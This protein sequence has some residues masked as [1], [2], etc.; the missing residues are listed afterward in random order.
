M[1]MILYNELLVVP[2]ATVSELGWRE[3]LKSAG[4]ATMRLTIEVWAILDA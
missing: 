3:K 1:L 2:I 4:L